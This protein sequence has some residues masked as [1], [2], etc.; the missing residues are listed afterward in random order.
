M[1][2]SILTFSQIRKAIIQEYRNGT[3]ITVPDDSDAA[4]RADGTSSVVEGL[5][6]HQLYIQRQLL[7]VPQMS[8]IYTFTLKN[9]IYPV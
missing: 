6:H 8:R 2:F 7:L 5:Y 1:A 3:G 4:I 9:S